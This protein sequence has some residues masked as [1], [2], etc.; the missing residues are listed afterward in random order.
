MSGISTRDLI[1]R[2]WKDVL[3]WLPG[4]IDTL[5]ITTGGMQKRRQ[6]RTGAQL[7]RLAFGY[8]VLDLSLRSTAAWARTQ[9]IADM[10][11]V[12]VYK[13][14]SAAPP[15]LEELLRRLLQRRVALPRV[16]ALPWRV[17]IVDSTTVSA[18][19]SNGADW[20]IHASYDPERG[21]FDAIEV[22]DDKGGEHLERGGPKAGDLVVA[23]RGYAHSMRILAL[24]EVRAH[25]LVR[26]GHSAVPMWTP[27]GERFDPVRWARRRREH[28]GRPPAVEEADVVLRGEDGKTCSARLVVVRKSRAA[29]EQERERIRRELSRKGR[30]PTART[31]AA[32]SFT[33]LLC[34]LPKGEA[35]P[36]LL[37][38]LYRVRW[39]VELGFKRWKS[40]LGL[41]EL[42]AREPGLARCYILAKLV[43]AVLADA[44]SRAPRDFSPWGYPL[45]DASEPLE[46]VPLGH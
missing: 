3:S 32:A 15:F 22:T 33:F 9:G 21:E 10:S 17:R 41:A 28:A 46:M 12:A 4:D 8:A 24:R 37:A 13:R 1:D 29:A 25:I 34:T 5:A 45:A 30:E 11:D 40:L 20:R 43:A 16:G 23:D 35:P 14:L 19:G 31:L 42:R 27:S 18:P 6:I 26:V 36:T 38:D 39:Q 2:S 44:I 7:L